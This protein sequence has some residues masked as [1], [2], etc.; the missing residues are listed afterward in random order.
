MKINMNDNVTVVLTED[1]AR[2]LNAA[3]AA[4]NALLATRY[5][6]A[7][8]YRAGDTVTEQLWVLLGKLQE[9]GLVWQNG[10]KVP[11]DGNAF[12]VGVA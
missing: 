2:A 9:G 7:A 5:A 1:G 12:T 8:V 4:S 10:V 6:D 11:F 3:T